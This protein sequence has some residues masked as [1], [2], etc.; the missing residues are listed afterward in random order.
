V[1]A[2]SPPGRPPDDALDAARATRGQDPLAR[3]E[4]LARRWSPKDARA[5]LAQDD[6][7]VRAA[8]KTSLADDLLFTRDALEQATPEEVAAERAERFAAFATVADLGAGIGLDA[9]ALARAGRRVRAVERDPER[10]ACLRHNVEAAGVAHLVEVIEGD[11]LSSPVAADAAFL[12]P[13][14]RPGGRRT[15]DA[16][17]F[18]PPLEAWGDLARRY[19]ALLVK[20]QPSLR[21]DDLADAG[22]AF[23]GSGVEWV[24]LRG[25]MKEARVGAG[26]LALA[27]PRRALLLPSRVVVEGGGE[28]WPAARAPRVGDVLLDPDPAVVLAGLVGD[29]CGTRWR[30]IHPRIAYLLGDEPAPWAD[31]LRV[32]AVLPAA[33]KALQ[34]WLDERDVSDLTIRSRGVKDPPDAWRRRLRVRGRGGPATLVLTRGPDGRYLGLVASVVGAGGRRSSMPPSGAAGIP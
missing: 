16:A 8:A 14:R 27:A 31:S 1:A 17:G 2:T 11:F 34:A 32:E 20:G 10:V 19:G 25:E 30:P 29:A 26:S 33:P 12:D 21:P 28:P 3:R 13:D 9:I 6:L 23:A 18:E 22:A 4:A 24:S 7:R 15:R 5:A